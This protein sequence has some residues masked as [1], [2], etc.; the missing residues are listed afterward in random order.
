MPKSSE[1][2]PRHNNHSLAAAV[3]FPSIRLLI[4]DPIPVCVTP[5]VRPLIPVSVHILF[6]EATA[7]YASDE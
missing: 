3:R 5:R 2:L 1:V 6:C 4:V 7:S